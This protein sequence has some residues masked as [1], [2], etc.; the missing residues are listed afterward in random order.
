M[1]R[2]LDAR[3]GWAG[4]LAFVIAGVLFVASGAEIAAIGG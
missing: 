3:Y 1:S 4:N 2:L